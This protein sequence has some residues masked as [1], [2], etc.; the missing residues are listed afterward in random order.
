MDLIDWLF[1]RLE[2][3]NLT[4]TDQSIIIV[5][6]LYFLAVSVS[7]IYW[8]DLYVWLLRSKAICKVTANE[9]AIS[10]VITSNVS[11]VVS[12]YLFD[13]NL[14]TLSVS[15]LVQRWHCLPCTTFCSLKGSLFHAAAAGTTGRS[16]D[17]AA[18]SRSELVF[19]SVQ[20]ESS[21][22]IQTCRFNSL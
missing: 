18:F 4:V 20:E 7:L 13:H 14:V 3:G 19:Y 1:K 11:R 2:L 22:S 17:S 6:K 9:N 21:S 5:T 8:I 12:S 16:I 15:H 10:S